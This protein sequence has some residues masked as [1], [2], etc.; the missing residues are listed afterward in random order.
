MSSLA[1]QLVA[2]SVNNDTVLDKKKRKKIHSVSLVF[3]PKIAVQQD[4]ETI[5]FGSLEALRELE[6]LDSRFSA[7]ENSLFSETSIHVDRTVQVGPVFF[8]FVRTVW[9]TT[10][11]GTK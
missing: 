11:F 8:F 5:F 1:A 10:D 9:L 6:I 4:Y 2:I 7:F 3:E